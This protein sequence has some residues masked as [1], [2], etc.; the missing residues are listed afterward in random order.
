MEV[1]GNLERILIRSRANKHTHT[2]THTH[3]HNTTVTEKSSIRK[4]MVGGG[5]RDRNLCQTSL[6]FL[7]QGLVFEFYYKW[8]RN[9]LDDYN[10]ATFFMIFLNVI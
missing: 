2:H 1:I 4:K 7:D 10:V 6:A 9:T 8:I 3:T 5:V